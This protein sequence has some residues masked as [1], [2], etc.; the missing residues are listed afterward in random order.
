MNEYNTNEWLTLA[1]LV[2]KHRVGGWQ[3]YIN[4]LNEQTKYG[5]MELKKK[6]MK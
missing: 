3:N 4:E 6:K 1:F 5:W 2:E